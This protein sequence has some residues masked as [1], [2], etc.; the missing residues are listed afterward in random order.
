MSSHFYTVSKNIHNPEVRFSKQRCMQNGD[1]PCTQNRAKNLKYPKMSETY[2]NAS[3]TLKRSQEVMPRLQTLFWLHFDHSESAVRP[4]FTEPLIL[5]RSSKPS[6]YYT[7]SSYF[8][9]TDVI[10]LSVTSGSTLIK[11]ALLATSSPKTNPPTK[12]IRNLSN[13]LV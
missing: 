13:L 4:N 5:H 9:I 8:L 7:Q 2:P 6:Q 10:A 3:V 1:L 12:C 11:M